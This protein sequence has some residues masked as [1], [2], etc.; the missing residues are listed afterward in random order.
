MIFFLHKLIQIVRNASDIY[1]EIDFFVN[2][3]FTISQCNDRFTVDYLSQLKI[4][5]LSLKNLPLPSGNNKIYLNLTKIKVAFAVRYLI[6]F[7]GPNV[8]VSV[9]LCAN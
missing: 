7:Y 1:C 2:M 5:A 8:C 3:Y 9:C 6:F 4:I